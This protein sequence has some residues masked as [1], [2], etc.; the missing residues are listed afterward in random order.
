[1]VSIPAVGPLDFFVFA[2]IGMGQQWLHSQ[3]GFNNAGALA[4]G[5][6]AS[7]AWF[8]YAAGWP[9]GFSHPDL[10]AWFASAMAYLGSPQLAAKG[11]GLAMRTDS[12]NAPKW[13]ALFNH[14]GSDATAPPSPPADPGPD[15]AAPGQ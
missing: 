4:L 2:L 10:S 12:A 9:A 1:M 3:K 6:L 11:F 13:L 15:S 7:L 14:G 5:L 8:G